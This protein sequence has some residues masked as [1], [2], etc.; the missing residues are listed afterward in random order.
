MGKRKYVQTT[1]MY[2]KRRNRYAANR[3]AKYISKRVTTKYRN[4]MY[5]RRRT[6]NKIGRSRY[7]LKKYRKKPRGFAGKVLAATSSLDELIINGTGK[8][9]GG[10]GRANMYFTPL[11][12]EWGIHDEIQKR[13]NIDQDELN[14]L[15]GN[16]NYFLESCTQKTEFVNSHAAKVHCKVWYYKT[17]RDDT[18]TPKQM[19]DRGI[20]QH[21][22]SLGVDS[23]VITPFM[24][25]DFTS[26]YKIIKSFSKTLEQGEK[27]TV[28]T[29]YSNKKINSDVFEA[30]NTTIR[31]TF[32]VIV[33]FVGDLS[34][35]GE[36]RV[37]T[38]S[39]T[40]V[41][42]HQQTTAKYRRMADSGITKRRLGSD[43]PI[44]PASTLVFANSDTGTAATITNNVA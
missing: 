29:N 15:D 33:R 26:G 32:G 20:N 42:F 43:L 9:V 23:T 1:I 11:N 2:P 7:Y 37:V 10:V 18:Q 5:T 41:M 6:S 35:G 31:G 13:I 14:L 3:T 21:G 4:G 36:P 39:N 34:I 44:V 24:S 8:T 30:G 28:V 17:R 19:F 40:D 12:L 16:V 25:R 38:T 27:L 22:L